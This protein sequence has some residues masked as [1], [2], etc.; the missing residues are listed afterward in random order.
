MRWPSFSG[1]WFLV[2]FLFGV[3]SALLVRAARQALV[4]AR[5]R[6]A[7]RHRRQKESRLSAAR[8]RWRLRWIRHL[9]G[10]HVAA[11]LFPLEDV[12]LEPRLLAWPTLVP[13]DETPLVSQ[14]HQEW[15]YLPDEP[16]LGTAYR[17]P[18]LTLP[19]ALQEGASLLLMGPAGSGKTVALAWLALR[20][21]Q[22]RPGDATLGNVAGLWPWW[23]HG[24]ALELP[25][26]QEDPLAP[27]WTALTQ[28]LS[29]PDAQ[30]LI[31]RWQRDA[32][33][34][35][36]LLL[37]D[38]LDEMPPVRRTRLVTFLER[39]RAAYP[40]VR[41]VVAGAPDAWG[42]LT[43]LGLVPMGMRI[44]DRAQATT[45]ARRWMAL[46]RD[47]VASRAGV[48]APPDDVLLH[49][50]LAAPLDVH[51][52]LYWTWRLWQLSAGDAAGEDWAALAAG[53]VRRMAALAQGKPERLQT[54]WEDL[55][56][57]RLWPL[58][59]KDPGRADA[60]SASG[61][62]GSSQALEEGV[63][64]GLLRAHRKGTYGFLQPVAQAYL[65]AQ[66]IAQGRG[67][68]LAGPWWHMLTWTLGFWAHHGQGS[69]AAQ[70][71]LRDAR[72]PLLPDLWEAARAI[73]LAPH[74]G[75]GKV[76]YQALAQ[77]VQAEDWPLGQRLRAVAA[78]VQARPPRLGTFFR[79]L[80][81]HQNQAVQA[82]AVVGLGLLR[83]PVALPLLRE[84]AS[85]QDISPFLRRML[86]LALARYDTRVI[87]EDLAAWL[88][89]ED[90]VARRDVAEALTLAPTW[91]YEVL[92]EAATFEDDLLIR[93]A[94]VYGLA[95]V[96]EPWAQELLETLRSEAPEWLV[97][98][99]AGQVLEALKE[100]APY[101][102][103]APRPL[104]EEVWLLA[105]AARQGL[106]IAVG[107]PAQETLRRAL[108]E[109]S[110]E[111]K[112]RALRRLVHLPDE[113]WLP[114]IGP[115][116]RHPSR[117]VENDALATLWF[118]YWSGVSLPLTLDRPGTQGAR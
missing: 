68:W 75:W 58:G 97:S 60:K 93:R 104:H 106:S 50:F 27:V 25:P 23:V 65:A 70:P 69:I 2:G 42:P 46:W 83:H 47:V 54:A 52:P 81:R 110:E 8:R 48:D 4:H 41:M 36:G 3:A 17:T 92:R 15:P 20:M 59:G 113:R 105:F 53:Y 117:L 94:A 40:D 98:N 6:W 114:D 18:S 62:G 84:M 43:A 108:T 95:K 103:K 100:K 38:G 22:A 80:L 34:G 39:V 109:G 73:R 87:S 35:R 111:E 99:A 33:K 24:D 21:L 79:S 12:I 76:V 44:W 11:P 26:P 64:A 90:A 115:L 37:V 86:F 61:G 102:P 88:L 16:M 66:V 14:V 82:A 107:P 5:A 51:S 63:R 13:P 45:F 55:A 7:Q 78:L 19:Q 118:F 30:L 112:R 49:W 72:Q 29:G 31:E 85:R 56:Y 10:L 74:V 89:E 71:L 28:G 9:Q 116:L 32:R 57:R 96:D 101:T 91:G 77:H 67:E 1:F